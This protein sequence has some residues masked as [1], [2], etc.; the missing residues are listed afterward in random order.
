[1]ARSVELN[2]MSY[3]GSVSQKRVNGSKLMCFK[4]IVQ[5]THSNSRPFVIL[6]Q[7]FYQKN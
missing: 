3:Y 4:P 6:G 5:N 2:S 1:M 7:L